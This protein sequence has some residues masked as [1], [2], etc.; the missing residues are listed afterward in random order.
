MEVYRRLPRDLRGGV[1]LFQEMGE[2]ILWKAPEEMDGDYKRRL[3]AL[4]FDPFYWSSA[5][6]LGGQPFTRKITFSDDTPSVM[7]DWIRDMDGS[8][9][10][11]RSVARGSCINAVGYGLDHLLAIWSPADGRP[12]IWRIP[13]ESVLDPKE[14]DGGPVRVQMTLYER[15]ENK[16]WIRYE[17][18]QIW[19]LY[20]GEPTAGGPDR[21]ARWKVYEHTKRRD[22]K[23]KWN[24]E[25]TTVGTF[26]PHESIPM[27]PLYTGSHSPMEREPWVVMPPNHELAVSNL[28]WLN[29]RSDLDHGLHL[30][31]IPQRA[32]AGASLEEIKDMQAGYGALLGTQSAQ[33]RI[34]FVEHSGAAFQISFTDLGELERRLQVMGSMPNVTRASVEG[35]ITATGELKDMGPAITR[36]QAWTFSWQDSLETALRMAARYARAYDAFS[37]ELHTDFGPA[38]K[39]L[40]R[41]R[42][43]QQDYI[44][45]DLHPSL[46]YQEMKRLGVYGEGFDVEA[47]VALALKTR[48]EAMRSFSAM[49]EPPRAPQNEP[50]ADEPGEDDE[51]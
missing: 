32:V 33:G 18:E 25:P 3:K 49:P 11:L 35:R 17:I 29:K 12:Y 2:E 40:D 10:D 48:E 22:P 28:V 27:V 34:Y 6:H 37:I 44:N 36:A 1:L 24:S 7:A 4:Q 45:G 31:N 38:D 51:E 16:P 42:I 8:G 23:S 46:Y 50:D 20:D 26:A 39:D 13:A 15:D 41:S 14:D 5:E 30:A 47:A 9:R 21:Y 43:I 19:A